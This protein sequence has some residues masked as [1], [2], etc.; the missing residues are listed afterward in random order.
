[1]VATTS[2][3]KPADWGASETTTA[4][5]V[6]STAATM[7]SMS[8]G[9][10]VRR[11]RTPAEMPCSAASAAAEGGPDGDRAVEPPVRPV[12]QAGQ[13]AGDLVEGLPG[14]PEELDLRHRHESLGGQPHGRPDDD[15]LRQRRVHYPGPAEP[16]EQPV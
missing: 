6:C 7:A 15:P 9:T 12:A 13:L 5:P 8:S 4:R 1:M 16:L 3:A 14:E 2:A 10:R 11:S